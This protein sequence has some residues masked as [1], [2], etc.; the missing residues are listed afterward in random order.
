MSALTTH[1]LCGL[2][3]ELSTLAVGSESPEQVSSLD[4]FMVDGCCKVHAKTWGLCKV[5]GAAACPCLLC[6]GAAGAQQSLRC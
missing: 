2:G 4:C 1:C 3:D 6:S 5:L